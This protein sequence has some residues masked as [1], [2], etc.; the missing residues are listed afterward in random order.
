MTDELHYT[1]N[2]TVIGG[3]DGL[4][5]FLAALSS[6]TGATQNEVA[7]T[8]KALPASSTPAVAAP[9]K[10]KRGPGRPKGAK[11]KPKPEPAPVRE[12]DYDLEPAEVFGGCTLTDVRRA[13]RDCIEVTDTP[14]ARAVFAK[15]G[16]AKIGDLKP[17]DYA[18]VVAALGEATLGD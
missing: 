13:L 8:P 10:S 9:S 5:R 14:T 18:A 4:T 7:E 3:A 2:L 12:T 1:V 17:Q 6:A 11:N 16:A 15:F